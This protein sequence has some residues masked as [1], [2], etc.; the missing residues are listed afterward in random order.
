[1]LNPAV[2]SQVRLRARAL[3]RNDLLMFAQRQSPGERN[4]G[5]LLSF[6]YPRGFPCEG[7]IILTVPNTSFFSCR[8]PVYL[9]LLVLYSTVHFFRMQAAIRTEIPASPP[10]QLSEAHQR[11]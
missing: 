4:C 8:D 11:I 7:A 6:F 2:K 1:M 10:P 9:L 3:T 5:F